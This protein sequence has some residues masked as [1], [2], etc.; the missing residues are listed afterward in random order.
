MLIHH[1]LGPTEQRENAALQLL[2][3]TRGGGAHLRCCVVYGVQL[4]HRRIEIYSVRVGRTA[5][6]YCN[7]TR[8]RTDFF[9]VPDD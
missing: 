4:R 6:Q 3:R 2:D 8:T 5:I 1:L 7:S 9:R